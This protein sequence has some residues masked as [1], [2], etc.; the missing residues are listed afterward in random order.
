MKKGLLIGLI[1]GILGLGV[2][3]GVTFAVVR[4]VVRSVAEK[5]KDDNDEKDGKDKQDDTGKKKPDK[6]KTEEEIDEKAAPAG[7]ERPQFLSAETS[8][9]SYTPSVQPYHTDTKLSNIDNR[10]YVGLQ[11]AQIEKLV[12]NNFVVVGKYNTEFFEQYEDNRYFQFPNFVTTDSMMHTYHLYF[13]LLQKK[14]EKEY[15]SDKVENMSKL[16]LNESRS[17]YE[18]LK[19]SEWETAALKNYAFFTVGAMLQDPSLSADGAVSDIVNGELSRINAMAG[20]DTSA[21]TGGYE[22]YSQYKPRGYYEGDEQLERYFRAMMW[23]GRINFAQND[24]ELDRCALL[25]TLALDKVGLEDW[26]AV[27]SVTSF[28]AGASDDS[29]YY[30]YMPL[31]REVYGENPSA[32]DL[33]GQDEKFAA[34]HKLTAKLD[35][36]KINSVPF[37]DDEGKTDKTEVAKGFRLMGQRFSLDEAIFTQLTYSKVKETSDDNKRLLPD[38]LDVPAALGSETAYELLDDMGKTDYPNY[39]DHL[40]K[41]QDEIEKMPQL[42]TGSLYAAWMNTLN[43]LLTEKGEGYPSFMTNK[44]WTKKSLETYLGSWTE[45]KHDTVLY[46][47]Q[48][49][50]EMGGG[51]E[52]IIDDRGYVEPVPELYDHLKNLTLE[53]KNGLKHYGLLDQNDEENLDRLADLSGQLCT[54]SIKELENETLTDDEYELIRSYGGSLEHFWNENVKYTTGEDYNSSGEF[55]AALA[56]DVATDPNGVVLQEAIGGLSDI[57]V[58]V[59]VDGSLRV[60]SGVV[61]NYY[62]FTMPIDKRLTDSEWRT[63]AGL[64]CD[65][66]YEYHEDPDLDK[67]KPDWTKSYRCEYNYDR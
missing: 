42:W 8:T 44:E 43:P 13:S 46:S 45:L 56:V 23:Y 33:K 6:N 32:S 49:M 34:F 35:P 26:E 10:E 41:A 12:E 39:D 52:E 9:L 20:I 14:T 58:V 5:V 63:M 25:M 28:F 4:T 29:G 15:L 7:L 16:L 38:A 18:E 1:A 62:Q 37:D 3:S 27:Y 2:L 50:A 55:P 36:P 64:L 40:H 48:M 57:Y 67:K 60:A 61:Y 21:I 17:M 54:I 59:P 51:D 19:G 24:E 11:D 30:E 65:D 66:N 53:T 22:D 47:K 31:I